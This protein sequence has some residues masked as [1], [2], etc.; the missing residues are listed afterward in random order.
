MY[1]CIYI[2]IQI[3]SIHI[4]THIYIHVR[5]HLDMWEHDLY[6]GPWDGRFSIANLDY[7]I[8]AQFECQVSGEACVW[9]G[10]IACTSE[11]DA[12]CGPFDYVMILGCGLI[13][14]M[15]K[16]WEKCSLS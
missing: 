6:M 1:V 14:N 8:A 16:V 5:I 11:D 7:L 2:Y 9:C 13:P 3:I 10:G 12:K 15:G 4:D